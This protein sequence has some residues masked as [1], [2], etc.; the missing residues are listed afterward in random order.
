MA[1]KVE[2]CNR[3]LSITL[4]TAVSHFDLYTKHYH[5]CSEVFNVLV[6]GLYLLLWEMTQTI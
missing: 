2:S 4:E 5:Y 6:S 3:K 1:N